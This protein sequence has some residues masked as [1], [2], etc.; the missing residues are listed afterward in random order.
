MS[1]NKEQRIEAYDVSLT[2]FGQI[3]ERYVLAFDELIRAWRENPDQLLL[4][5]WFLLLREHAGAVLL[6]A[7]FK[8]SMTVCIHARGMYETALNGSVIGA[9]GEE[10]LSKM[11]AHANSK[12]HFG[13][14]RE[15]AIGDLRVRLE[16][17]HG[18]DEEATQHFRHYSEMFRNRKDR[19]FR[20]WTRESIPD[21]LKIVSSLVGERPAALLGMAHLAVYR[22]ASEMLHGTLCGYLYWS[23]LD[24][25]TELT[26]E[27]PKPGERERYNMYTINGLLQ[28]ISVCFPV[29]VDSASKSYPSLACHAEELYDQYF[30]NLKATRETADVLRPTK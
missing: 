8:Q 25:M 12:T 5:P 1:N 3:A 18:L 6:A 11:T 13:F 20:E 24:D 21:R 9:K 4:L 2:R 10:Y 19:E 30:A 7:H 23:G 14:N 22:D 27:D 15:L 26:G 29:I 16:K 28:L 17:R